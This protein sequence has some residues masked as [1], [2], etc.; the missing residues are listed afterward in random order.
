MRPARATR[1]PAYRCRNLPQGPRAYI[2]LTDADTGRRR[3]CNLG[4]F[5]SPQSRAR[6][7]ELLA[8]W[9]RA[10]RR[11][12]VARS[13]EDEH[14]RGPTVA[15]LCWAYWEAQ[16]ERVS[17]SQTHWIAML[18][19]VLRQ[20]YGELPARDFRPT[21]LRSVRA[22]L[23][24]GDPR[25]TPRRKPWSR[26]IANRGARQI[27]AIFRWGVSHELVG[28]DVPAAL[29]TLEPLRRGELGAR[30]PA[31]VGPVPDHVL[32]AT[33]PH[34]AP[35]VRAMVDLQLLTGMRS[36][37]LVQM[38]PR[39]IDMSAPVW[40]YRPQ[41]HKTE[42]HGFDRVVHLGP[43]AQDVLRPWLRT[44]LDEPIWRGEADTPFDTTTYR[45]AV[46]RACDRADRA[47]QIAAGRLLTT[48]PVCHVDFASPEHLKRHVRRKHTET[49][50]RLPEPRERLV[51]LWHPHQLRHNHAT[52]VR[53]HFGAE[54]ARA[55]LGHHSLDVTEIY[56]ERDARVAAEVAAR[57]G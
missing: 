11:L 38:R 10:G 21:L 32:D 14:G 54:A 36:G 12:P 42:H 35:I 45:K 13:R 20:L 40:V 48:C 30:E 28:P 33:R 41:R 9:E 46:Q 17:P 4:P 19:R 6:Y 55:V 50:A 7:A 51:P 43:R 2:T 24:A 39:D 56:A 31:P 5:G 1:P 18:V 34:L 22:A 29:A 44:A 27:I 49:G 3:D 52:E 23:V 16:R 37:E 25:A 47:A 57:L 53:R 8:A 15:E 26:P